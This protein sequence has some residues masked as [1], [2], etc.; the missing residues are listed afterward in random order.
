MGGNLNFVTATYASAGTKLEFSAPCSLPHLLHGRRVWLCLNMM[1]WRGH[2]ELLFPQS[3]W[4]TVYGSTVAQTW[5]FNTCKH[6]TQLWLQGKGFHDAFLVFW[7]SSNHLYAYWGWGRGVWVRSRCF[8]KSCLC[9]WASLTP[10]GRECW[11]M[12]QPCNLSSCSG[13]LLLENNVLL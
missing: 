12:G 8:G 1:L 6:Y 10:A 5:A 9:S 13:L 3:R 11:G 2:G 4:N 7:H